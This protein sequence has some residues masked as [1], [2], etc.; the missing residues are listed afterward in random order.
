MLKTTPEQ[1]N[2]IDKLIVKFFF[3][4]NI[5]FNEA[6]NPPFQEMVSALRPVY[7]AP[8]IK[9]WV[10]KFLSDKCSKIENSLKKE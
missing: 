9:Q 2:N 3:G 8:S 5:P 6:G 1:K 10:V 7:N 4:S